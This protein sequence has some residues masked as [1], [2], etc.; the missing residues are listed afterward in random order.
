MP[1]SITDRPT[2]A[3]EHVFLLAKSERYFFDAFPIREEEV[4]PNWDN[5]TRVFGGKNKSVGGLKHNTG[6]VAGPRKRGVPPYHAQYASS[7]QSSLDSAGRGGGRH[8]RNVW[9]IPSQPFSAK[10][11]PGW[12]EDHDHYAVMPPALVEKCLL[13]AT[14]AYGQCRECGAPW[15][16]V[17]ETRQE[18]RG[19]AGK[20]GTKIAGKGHATTQ[21]REQHDIREGPAT[22]QVATG[23]EPS[24]DCLLPDPVPQHVLDPFGGAGTTALVADRHQRHCTLVE[25][26]PKS[27]RLA[28]ARLT[29]DAPLL[30]AAQ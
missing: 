14:S 26:N 2:S 12:D 29:A 24:C 16:R 9:T 19:N 3:Y 8:P 5:G 15:A 18:K 28:R 6:R 27:A 17:I 1:E 11:L 4:E 13:S 23:W 10:R 20:R 30:A 21:V 7:D 25:L 22:V